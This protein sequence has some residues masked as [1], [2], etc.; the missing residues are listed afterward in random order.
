MRSQD[1]YARLFGARP[2]W[3]VTDQ[4][5]AHAALSHKARRAF[6]STLA[7]IRELPERGEG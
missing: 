4:H 6:V 2:W 7:D 3:A 1:V 5:V